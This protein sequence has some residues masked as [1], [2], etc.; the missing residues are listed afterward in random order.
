MNTTDPLY[1][2]QIVKSENI[3]YPYEAVI[4]HNGHRLDP[5]AARS[6]AGLL[7]RTRDAIMDNVKS[8]GTKPS[9]KPAKNK[10]KAPAAPAVADDNDITIRTTDEASGD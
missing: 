9:T 2:I 7:G 10:P 4:F 6:I 5:V 3:L 8:A 1:S